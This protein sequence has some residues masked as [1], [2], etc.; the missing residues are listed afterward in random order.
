[1]IE[2]FHGAKDLAFTFE[3]EGLK[4]TRENFDFDNRTSDDVPSSLYI[5]NLGYLGFYG[6]IV[7]NYDK[8]LL[9]VTFEN[10][11]L[12]AYPAEELLWKGLYEFAVVLDGLPQPDRPLVCTLKFPKSLLT[13]ESQFGFGEDEL[14]P[15]PTLRY[16]A[17]ADEWIV[18]GTNLSFPYFVPKDEQFL[19]SLRFDIEF[20]PESTNFEHREVFNK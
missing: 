6:T 16:Y 2:E 9:G 18:S 7:Y 3:K 8:G 1:M 19:S 12:M 5:P 14:Q 15:N 13:L 11:R 20:K 4:V 10:G 17:H